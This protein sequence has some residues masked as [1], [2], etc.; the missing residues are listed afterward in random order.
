MKLPSVTV[1]LLISHAECLAP[2][3]PGEQIVKDD[4]RHENRSQQVD[5]QADGHRDREPLDGACSEGEK[6]RRGGHGSDARIDDRLESVFEPSRH[7][8]SDCLAS[9]H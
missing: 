2:F 7:G 1:R 8:G 5:Y 9:T 6:Y 4:S 3:T